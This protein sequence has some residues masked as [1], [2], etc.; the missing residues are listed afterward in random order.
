MKN[1]IVPILFVCICFCTFA[2]LPNKTK[3]ASAAYYKTYL[4][5]ITDTNSFGTNATINDLGFCYEV[6]AKT[7]V[8]SSKQNTIGVSA[9]INCKK[10]DIN[11]ILKKH[12]FVLLKRY[13]IK[14]ILVFEGKNKNGKKMQVAYHS[15][16]LTIGTPAIIGSY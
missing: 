8:K 11:K 13:Q 16:T 14:D 6:V 3:S 10:Q 7:K 2:F 1:Y 9:I 15:G 5:S 4:S 12:G